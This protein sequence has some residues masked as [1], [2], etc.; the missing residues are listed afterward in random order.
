MLLIDSPTISRYRGAPLDYNVRV[1][2]CKHPFDLKDKRTKLSL[3]N[4]IKIELPLIIK[5][6]LGLSIYD[7]TEKRPREYVE[8]RQIFMSLMRKYTVFSLAKIA[9]I[10]DKDHASVLASQ[11]TVKNLCDTDKIFRE[12]YDRIETKVKSI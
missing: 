2:K 11:K 1:A 5:D 8:A 4:K 7:F 6:E 3:S 10:V 9:K 12:K